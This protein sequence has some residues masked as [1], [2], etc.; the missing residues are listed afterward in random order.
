MGVVVLAGALLVA[1]AVAIEQVPTRPTSVA[2]S[3]VLPWG[4]V[5]RSFIS[6]A[7]AMP[8][9]KWEFAPTQGEFK[10][11]RTFA[12][13][14]KHV[15]CGNFAFFA[16]FEGKTPPPDCGTGG[17]SPAKTKAE[18][19]Q[20]LRGSFAYADKVLATLTEKNMLDAVDGPYFTPNTKLGIA[21]QKRDTAVPRKSTQVP[22]FIAAAIPKPIPT[23]IEKPMVNNPNWME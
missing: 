2:A 12:E 3:V 7:D 13:Q 18:L 23:M 21:R 9:D 20:Y 22:C 14:V 11:V 15:A 1:S 19:M 8:A 5:E 17:P 4:V 16:E 10:G 6:L